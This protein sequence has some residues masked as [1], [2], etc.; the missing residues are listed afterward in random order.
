MIAYKWTIKKDNK[1]YPLVNFGINLWMKINCSP[2]EIGKIY[3]YNGECSHFVNSIRKRYGHEIDGFHF[4]KS[5]NNDILNRWNI[6]LQQRKQPTINAT[7]LCEVEDII[8]ETTCN[9]Y[10]K[11]IANKFKVLKEI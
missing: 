2:Y 11:I 1:Y 5:I 9:G 4:W 6:F 7:L 10:P 8:K 3:I